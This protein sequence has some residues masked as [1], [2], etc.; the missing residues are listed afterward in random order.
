MTVMGSG[1]LKCWAGLTGICAEGTGG[2]LESVFSRASA[3]EMLSSQE[4]PTAVGL[5]LGTTS[6]PPDGS[7]ESSWMRG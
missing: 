1:P 5:G 3:Q 4:G 6:L 7:A 2:V